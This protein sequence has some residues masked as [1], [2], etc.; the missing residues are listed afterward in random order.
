MHMN[1]LIV[2]S[3]LTDRRAALLW[4]LLQGGVEVLPGTLGTEEG[5]SYLSSVEQ[6]A[7]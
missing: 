6:S 1:K 3:F 4:A 5:A 2:I 7:E